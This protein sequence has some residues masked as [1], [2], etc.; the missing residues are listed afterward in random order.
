MHQS[1]TT[2]Y[3]ALMATTHL[4]DRLLDGVGPEAN[5]ADRLLALSLLASLWLALV[6]AGLTLL[7]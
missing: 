5:L 4:K 1:R 3:P 6:S 2:G 7:R